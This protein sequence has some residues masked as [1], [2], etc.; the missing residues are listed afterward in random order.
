MTDV[1]AED[2]RASSRTP[3]ELFDLSGRAALVTGGNRGLGKHF[4]RVLARAGARVMIAASDADRLERGRRELAAEG[5]EVETCRAD[6]A[7]AAEIEALARRAL[8]VLGCVDILVAN[9]GVSFREPAAE[10]ADRS[11]ETLVAVNLVAPLLLTRG[12]V[13]MMKE[14]GWGRLIY[15]SS[16]AASHSSDDGHSVYS[17]TKAG[18]EAYART[19]AIELGPHGITANAIAPGVF[20][21]DMANDALGEY[22]AETRAVYDSY[23]NMTALRRWGEPRELEGALLLL[24]SDAGSYITGSTIVVDGGLT[25]RLTPAR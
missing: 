18:L 25:V 15:V 3:A 7:V 4:A 10:F 23:A 17:A 9:A 16:V 1:R 20:L 24:A 14:R 13:P 19:A 22:G 21:T 6:L 5:A 11:M 2:P 8:E 12:L